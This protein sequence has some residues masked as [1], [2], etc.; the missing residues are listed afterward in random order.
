MA[1]CIKVSTKFRGTEYLE[2]KDTEYQSLLLVERAYQH[3]H[4]SII[5]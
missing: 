1:A 4:T 3:F 2:K 5:R